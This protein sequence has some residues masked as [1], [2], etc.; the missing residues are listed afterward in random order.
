MLL[1]QLSKQRFNNQNLNPTVDGSEIRRSPVEVEVGSLSVY[2]IIYKV[3]YMPGGD[4]RTSEPSTV[5]TTKRV[6]V[7]ITVEAWQSFRDIPNMIH[8]KSC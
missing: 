8:Q 6:R 1:R 5:L 4:R 3:L 7:T 2:P